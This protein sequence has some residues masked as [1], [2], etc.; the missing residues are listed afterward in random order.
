MIA[1][2]PAFSAYQSAAQTPAATTWTKISFQS[3][4]FDTASAFDSAS[5][6]RFTPQTAGYYQING[7]IGVNGLA[8][9]ECAIYKNGTV[10]KAGSLGAYATSVGA[11]SAAS[12]LVYL[13][14]S[15]DYVELW[16]YL[17][18]SVPLL[19]SASGTYFQASLIRA[20]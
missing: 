5:T 18:A 15:T 4:E 14:G 7:A 3:E 8:N 17:S 2:G 9:P 19:A 16:G 10:F 20:A 11:V 13:N 6:Y 12:A 1:G